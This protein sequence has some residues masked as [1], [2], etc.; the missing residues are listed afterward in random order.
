MADASDALMPR[1]AAT[2]AAAVGYLLD[3]ARGRLV[4]IISMRRN[5]MPH[6]DARF[7][8]QQERAATG[9]LSQA[10]RMLLLL[11]T[12]ST[13]TAVARIFG[14]HKRASASLAAMVVHFVD[15]LTQDVRTPTK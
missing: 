14:G 3:D 2:L 4:D 6:A 1:F 10:R 5:R 9:F 13:E 15:C 8:A 11:C 7:L 12:L